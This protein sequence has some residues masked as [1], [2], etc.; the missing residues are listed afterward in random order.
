M[1]NGTSRDKTRGYECRLSLR[2]SKRI[3]SHIDGPGSALHP[4][5]PGT[6]NSLS[7]CPAWRRLREHQTMRLSSLQVGHVEDSLIIWRAKATNF[8]THC[9]VDVQLLVAGRRICQWYRRVGCRVIDQLLAQ[10]LRHQISFSQSP[11]PRR[12]TRSVSVCN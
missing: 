4:L 12:F 10:G 5:P 6:R 11:A 8:D 2:G 9:G 1:P 7:P 3:E